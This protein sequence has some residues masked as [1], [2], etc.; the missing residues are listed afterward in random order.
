MRIISFCADGIV[1][2][3]ERGFFDW[4]VEQDAEIICIQDLRAREYD[5]QDDIY[6]PAGYFPYFFDSPDRVNGVA[7][8]CRQVPKAIM[9]GVGLPN[10]DHEAR[11]IQADYGQV[12]IAS[13]LAPQAN[14][15]DSASLEHKLEF[16]DHFQ[17]H[18]DKVRNKRRE[19]ILCGNWGVAHQERDVA[20]A[21]LA[22]QKPGFLA[23]ERQ[24]L[25]TVTNHLGYVDAFREINSDDDEF[26]WQPEEQPKNAMRVDYQIVSGDLKPSIEYGALYKTQSF[27]SHAPLIM[28]YDL[29]L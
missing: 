23:E 12:T 2:A 5:L 26:S 18:L 28:D 8:Y 25:N 13:L 16:A 22:E 10:A 15:E 3:A 29:E 19:F 27:S 14:A 21:S 6:Y 24:W 9:T 1:Q 4:A 17:N 11:Y 20:N 7:I